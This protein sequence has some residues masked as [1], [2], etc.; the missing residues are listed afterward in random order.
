VSI[1]LYDQSNQFV[2]SGTTDV[3]GVLT[4]SLPEATYTSYYYKQGVTIT[5]PVTLIVSANSK[6]F[7]VLATVRVPRASVDNKL[8]TVFGFVNGQDGKP[9]KSV[10]IVLIPEPINIIN[11]ALVYTQ[12]TTVKSDETGWFEFTLLKNTKYKAQ[13]DGYADILSVETANQ[14]TV[15]I[16]DFLF[17]IP[18]LLTLSSSNVTLALLNGQNTDTT[19]TLRYTDATYKDFST[20]W[21]DLSSTH[22]D[23]SIAEIH[24][25]KGKL[26]IVPLKRGT[27]V[28]TITRVIRPEY[29]W[30]PE[31]QFTAP[32]LTITVT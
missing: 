24:Y 23:S 10:R 30:S 16:Q 20:P 9:I 21:S 28:I 2:T 31:P 17:P 14:E 22:T 11:T 25:L 7:I 5:Q 3:N 12:T 26:L 18:V 19:Y 1:N 13:L 29:V 6:N 15:L 8:I 32:V 27:T 4:L